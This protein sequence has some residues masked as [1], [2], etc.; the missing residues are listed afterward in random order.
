MA[1]VLEIEEQEDDP[2][3]RIDLVDYNSSD[4][5]KFVSDIKTVNIEIPPPRLGVT[6]TVHMED[7]QSEF[8]KIRNQKRNTRC[9]LTAEHRQ[10]Q[11]GDSFDYSNSDL[12]NVINIGRDAHTV[13][14]SRRK[15]REEEEAYNP[16]S[17]YRLP[18]NYEWN[19]RKRCHVSPI[20]PSPRNQLQSK[21][22]WTQDHIHG[23]LHAQCFLHPKSKHSAFQCIT[24]RKALGAPPSPV[25]EGTNAP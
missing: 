10:Q 19:S 1:I 25:D 20:P 18:D 2:M 15:E 4:Y 13:I 16:T 24:L 12:R 8:K 3:G 14:I 9:R 7:D 17:N 21:A 5:D 11:V 22:P 6:V 23:K